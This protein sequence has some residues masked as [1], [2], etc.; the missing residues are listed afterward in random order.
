M[1]GAVVYPEVQ[2]PPSCSY[3]VL[4]LER[5]VNHSASFHPGVLI[6]TSE[7]NAGGCPVMD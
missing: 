6:S 3:Y 5:D 7:F 2:V 4:F 1:V